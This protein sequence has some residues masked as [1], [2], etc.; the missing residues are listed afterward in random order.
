MT[1]YFHWQMTIPDSAFLKDYWENSRGGDNLYSVYWL[2]NITGDNSL[3]GLAGKIHRN[4]AN[5]EQGNNLPN[6]HNVNIAQC[7]REPATYWLLS[8]NDRDLKATYE[9]FDLIRAKYG[10]VPGGMFGSDENSRPGYDD[11]RQAVETCGMLEQMASDEMLFRFTSDPKWA[12]NCE[13]VTFNTYPAAFMPDQRS[14][15]YLTSPNM[16]VSDSKDHH[17]GID[18]PG[19]Y[20]MMNPFSSRCC[21][22]NHSSGW[23]YY[24]ENLTMATPDNGLAAV[25]YA[26]S[27]TK[28]A[29][30]KNGDTVRVE[31]ETH[32]PFEENV[33]FSMHARKP[34]HFPFYLRIPS[35]AIDAQVMVNGKPVETKGSSG[36]YVRIERDWKEGDRV[37]L[38]LPM[39][40]KM[41]SWP[42]NKNSVSLDYGPITWSLKIREDYKLMDGAGTAQWDS[43]WLPGTDRKQWPSYEIL[44]ASAWNY[45]LVLEGGPSS[46]TALKVVRKAWP[47]DDDPFTVNSVPLEVMVKGRRIPDWGIDQYGLT[48]V[49]PLS[50]VA[51]NEPVES[52]TLI[53]MGAA[54]LRISSFPVIK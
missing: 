29:V 22:H 1:K 15:R 10:Q 39:S 53:P 9:D 47:K 5:W 28:A 42:Q 44:P 16:A 2:Y 6:W 52:I 14:L 32:Y 33:N 50:P 37:G 48:S 38:R 45:G 26:T 12:E 25:F 34:L 41:R 20:L 31:E 4:T 24:A 17:P 11:P 43:K 3:L 7:F 36:K 54:R 13:D 49:L 40:M 19:P 21:Q 23:V 46:F 18:N 51:S 27:I 35:W 30:G 8:G